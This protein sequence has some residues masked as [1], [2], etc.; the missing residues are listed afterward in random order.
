M[1]SKLESLFLES[2]GLP[3]VALVDGTSITNL[4]SRLEALDVPF[5]SLLNGWSATTYLRVAPFLVQVDE[6][7]MRMEKLI[8]DAIS[9]G[10]LVWLGSSQPLERMRSRLF[11]FYY[12]RHGKNHVYARIADAMYF[13][14]LLKIATAEQI[15][16]IGAIAERV[17]IPLNGKLDTYAFD[18]ESVQFQLQKVKEE[19]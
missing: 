5:V 6:P 12:W 10:G 13:S 14:T 17:V 16:M 8:D 19:S 2:A 4:Y 9:V 18:G 11:K 7:S 3:S 1:V 15:K